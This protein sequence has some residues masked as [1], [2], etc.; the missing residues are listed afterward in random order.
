[1]KPMLAA[2]LTLA[3]VNKVVFPVLGSPKL[4]GVRFFTPNG[5]P[6]SRHLKEI[7]NLRVQ[8]FIRDL[9]KATPGHVFDGEMVSGNFGNTQS[10]VST[11]HANT[12][13]QL[14]IFDL[15]LPGVAAVARYNRLCDLEESFKA[16]SP[17]VHVV[18]QELIKG[19]FEL[20]Q[21]YAK[22]VELGFEGVCL[23]AL[24]GD[25]KFGRST[26]NQQF[27]L[28][29]K[30]LEDM[31]ARIVGFEQ[32][33]HNANEPTIN[34]LGYQVRSSHQ[35]GMVYQEALGAF[36]V[37]G[38]NGP[39]EGVE[40]NVGSGLNPSQRKSF[41][42]TRD[43]LRG[44]IITVTYQRFGSKNKPRTPIFKGFRSEVDYQPEGDEVL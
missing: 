7:P 18:E 11:I 37:V 21:Y 34:E 36:K 22:Q 38:C 19:V 2:T 41:W 5:E 9:C 27:L 3:D 25:Y 29:M 42:F 35:H 15:V 32:F 12:N 24:R 43:T 13:V 44:K 10:A 20:E 23:R 1:M 16:Y 8:M 26:F 6:K 40:F 31:E 4:D 39:F 30:A 28:K 14:H 33:A 17:Y